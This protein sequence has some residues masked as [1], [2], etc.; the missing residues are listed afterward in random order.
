MHI[1]CLVLTFPS[2]LRFVSTKTKHFDKSSPKRLNCSNMTHSAQ[3]KALQYNSYLYIWLYLLILYLWRMKNLFD[4]SGLV[5]LWPQWG[6]WW[7]GLAGVPIQCVQWGS[8]LGYVHFFYVI[9]KPF[10]PYGPHFFNLHFQ[11]KNVLPR[12]CSFIAHIWLF[13]LWEVSPKITHEK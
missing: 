1:F 6:W 5:F 9:T 10:E 8:N 13:G 12:A 3:S 2:T 7:W 4:L 11:M